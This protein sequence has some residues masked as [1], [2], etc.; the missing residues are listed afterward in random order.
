[1]LLA[2][3]R[4][5]LAIAKSMDPADANLILAFASEPGSL[6]E[7]SEEIEPFHLAASPVHVR[8]AAIVFRFEGRHRV[9]LAKH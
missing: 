4:A 1:M 9:A 5:A 3:A 6:P 2:D 8:A 7:H